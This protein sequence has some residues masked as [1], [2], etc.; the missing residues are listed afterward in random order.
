L[1]GI[2]S[3]FILILI[4]KNIPEVTFLKLCKYNKK[5]QERIGLSINDY[6]KYNQIEIELIL[7]EDY[8]I[9]LKKYP[10]S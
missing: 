4:F 6:K 10:D 7:K 9:E 3:Q 1:N 2:K 8:N 5:L